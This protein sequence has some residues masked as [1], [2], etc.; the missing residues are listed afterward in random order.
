MEIAILIIVSL[1]LLFCL[2]QSGELGKLDTKVSTLYL[3]LTKGKSD[4]EESTDGD[5]RS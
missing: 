1:N 4:T 5:Q 2:E 3:S